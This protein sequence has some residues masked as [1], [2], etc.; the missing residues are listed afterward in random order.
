MDLLAF[1]SPTLNFNLEIESG[2]MLGADD[3]EGVESAAEEDE[4]DFFEEVDL[5]VLSTMLD[6]EEEED[7]V[8]GGAGDDWSLCSLFFFFSFSFRSFFF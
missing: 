3:E 7:V 5:G 6:L 1:L 2:A 4:E 8:G